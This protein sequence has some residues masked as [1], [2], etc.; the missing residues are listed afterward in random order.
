MNILITGS[1]GYVGKAL[2]KEL[3]SDHNLFLLKNSTS[4]LIEDNCIYLNLM[5]DSHIEQ[6]SEKHFN[7]DLIIHTASKMASPETVDDMSILFDNVKM[8]ENLTV[9][10]RQ[11]N[12]KRIINFSTIAVYPNID[13]EYLETSVIDPSS[14]NDALYGL[15]KVCGENILNFALRNTSIKIMHLRISQIYSEEM[16]ENRLYKVMIKE[17][18][19][20]NQISV[21]GNGERTSNFIHLDTLVDIIKFF[22]KIEWNNKR[23]I[24]NIGEENYT[25]YNFAKMVIKKF[26]DKNSVIIRKDIGSKSKFLLNTDKY[27][28][29]RESNV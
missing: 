16:A 11:F 21:Y 2:S 10:A 6:L 27:Q 20:K 8:Y 5:D 13:G 9:I 3:K 29:F 22:I 7:I 18:K 15:S 17:L 23:D 4:F 19:E 1:N 24:Y 25:Y 12:I 14:N 26:G 28:K